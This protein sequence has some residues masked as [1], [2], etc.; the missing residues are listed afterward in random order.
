MDI[1]VIPDDSLAEEFA[2][3]GIPRERLL[4]V[5]IPVRGEFLTR[6]DNLSAKAACGLPTEGKHLLMMC[7]SMGCGPMEKITE[8][9]ARAARDDLTVSILCGTNSVLRKKLERK[10]ANHP[11]LRIC[12][13]VDDVALLMDSADL[14]LTKP[15]GISVTESMAKLLPMVFVDAVAGCEEYNL[16]YFVERGMACV[17]NTP[18][19]IAARCLAL[20]DDQQARVRMAE[21]MESSRHIDAAERICD[22]LLAADGERR[23][24]LCGNK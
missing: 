13:Y 24:A 20:L 5:G 22:A 12:G 7:G 4:G 8:Q 16:R 10:Y 11:R 3:C 23:D 19:A 1:Y 2:G 14:Y 18:R 6:R 9:F 17:E 21:R 15:G